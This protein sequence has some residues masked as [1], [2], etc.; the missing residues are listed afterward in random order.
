MRPTGLNLALRDGD[1][2]EAADD[3][4]QQRDHDEAADAEQQPHP[5]RRRRRFEDFQGGR[6]ELPVDRRQADHLD[7]LDG[8]LFRPFAGRGA[9][10]L[11]T[12]TGCSAAPTDAHRDPWAR[13]QLVVSAGSTIRP[14]TM[15]MIR[16]QG[17]TAARRWAMMITVRLR[18]MCFMLAWMIRSLS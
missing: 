9:G 18:T 12:R 8:H 11:M 15:P 7:H 13:Q 10:M 3:R 4:P 16:L 5:H 2:V 14:S 1:D 17:R 6:Q